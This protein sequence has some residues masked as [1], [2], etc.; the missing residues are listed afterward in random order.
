MKIRLLQDENEIALACRWAVETI[1]AIQAYVQFFGVAL[2]FVTSQAVDLQPLRIIQ[3]F[4]PGKDDKPMIAGETRWPAFP[5]LPLLN[6]HRSG[7]CLTLPIADSNATL[8]L[9]GP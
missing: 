8:S 3:T 9:S 7:F 6:V 4:L 1:R 5:N 2:E